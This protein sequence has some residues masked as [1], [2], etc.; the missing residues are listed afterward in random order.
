VDVLEFAAHPE[1]SPPVALL[2]TS[3]LKRAVYYPFATFSP[4]GRHALG[5]RHG[6]ARAFHRPPAV[7]QT[8]TMVRQAKPRVM[9]PR[10]VAIR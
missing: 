5:A 9:N 8:P 7:A 4:S 3:G 10:R 6:R 1:M 2:V